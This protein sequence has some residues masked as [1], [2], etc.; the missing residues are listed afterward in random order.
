MYDYRFITTQRTLDEVHY[1]YEFKQAV[2][3]GYRLAHFQPR[4]SGLGSRLILVME[5]EIED[6]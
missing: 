4:D 5:K 6:E 1:D 2:K 3:D